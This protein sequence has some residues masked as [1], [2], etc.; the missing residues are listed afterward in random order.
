MFTRRA[1]RWT[2]GLGV[3]LAWAMSASSSA[4]AW[5][6]PADG[7]VLRGFSVSSDTYAA[8]QHRGIDI[9]LGESRVIRAPASGQVSFAGQ[10]PTHGLTVT[11]AT[12]DGYK[13]SLTHL[14]T[15]R[16]RKGASVTEGD[17]IADLG[18]T[19]EAEHDVAYLYLGIRVGA[20]E[21][22]VDP[23][24]LLPPRSAPNPPPAPPAPPAS[25]PPPASASPPAAEQP[26]PT[27]A[28]DP[29]PPVGSGPSS[30]PAAVATADE[31]EETVGAAKAG[32]V[33]VASGMPKRMS[34]GGST[35]AKNE[36]APAKSRPVVS[37]AA[38]VAKLLRAHLGAAIGA[39]GEPRRRRLTSRA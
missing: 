1:T 7:P 16:I 10:V 25:S 2:I 35:S 26:A 9:A 39:L 31:G 4:L 24:E 30:P 37:A 22:Y 3:V 12:S 8:G 38:A 36:G 33:M 32:L 6:W 13:A 21:A 5:T 29:S 15:L 20:A 27:A 34:R 14:G 18:P 28:P 11:I 17:P 23:L 19:G